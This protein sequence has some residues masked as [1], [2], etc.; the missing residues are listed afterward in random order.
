MHNVDFFKQPYLLRKAAT[1]PLLDKQL[2]LQLLG[3]G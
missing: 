3:L 1:Y 2:P